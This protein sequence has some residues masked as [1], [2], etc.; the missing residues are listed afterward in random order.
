MPMIFQCPFYKRDN[1]LKLYCEGGTV[2][3]PD[4]PART[5]YVRGFCA[6]HITWQKCTIAHNLQLYY[7][8]K[9]ME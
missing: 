5:E 2:K 4:A 3:F 6:N 7:D 8:R 1:Y 9:E